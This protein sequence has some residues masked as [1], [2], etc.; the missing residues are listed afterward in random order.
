MDLIV[1]TLA[2]RPDLAPIFDVFPD[3]WAEFL[4][5]DPITEQLFDRLVARHPES[6]LI[7]IDR[8]APDVPIARACAFPFR[9]TGDPD[10]DLPPGGY[11]RVLLDGFTD[12][13]RGSVAAALEVTIRPDMR[14]SG[15]SRVML[16]ALRGTLRDLGYTSLVVPVRPNEKHRWPHESMATYLARFRPDGLP[17]DPWLR[18][19]VRAGARIVG[20]APYSMTV[21]GTLEEWRAWTGLPF[22]TSG[23]VVVPQALVAVNCDMEQEIATYVEPNVWVHHRL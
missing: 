4:Y 20:I 3:S 23:P 19:H 1:G 7:A 10:V 15:L 12:A 22:D 6:N 5:H 18:T 21:L 13:P 17:Q 2:D 8:D 11:D 14:G 9:W 16:D